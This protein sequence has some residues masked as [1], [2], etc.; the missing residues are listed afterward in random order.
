MAPALAYEKFLAQMPNGASCGKS[1]GHS[2]DGYT[3]FGKLWKTCDGWAVACKKTYPGTSL[4]VGA[5]L[6]D[7]CCKWTVGG[8]PDFDTKEPNL[9]GF[10]CAADAKPSSA[11]STAP[12]TAPSSGPTPRPSSGKPVTPCPSNA[13]TVAPTKAPVTVAPTPCP[14]TPSAK[15]ATGAPTPCPTKPQC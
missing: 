15:P 14:T 9:K 3:E 4:T 10:T 1:L 13:T 7:P 12:S 2:G 5:V 11:P 8:K 6:G